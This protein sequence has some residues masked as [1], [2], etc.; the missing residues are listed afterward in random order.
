M[1]SRM[2]SNQ[3]FVEQFVQIDIKETPKSSLLSFVRGFHRSPMDSPHK[4]TMTW[5]MFPF[6]DVIMENKFQVPVPYLRSRIYGHECDV[7]ARVIVI[8]GYRATWKVKHVP[9]KQ[10]SDTHNQRGGV[11]NHRRLHCL[12]NRL[13]LRRSK[14]ISKHRV[15]GLCEGN[16]P[17]TGDPPRKHMPC[18]RQKHTH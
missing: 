5:T 14:K 1:A 18:R 6:D 8:S 13:F 11:S 10:Y 9:F 3:V 7:P 4:G 12:L 17:V 16:P 2:T 15:T